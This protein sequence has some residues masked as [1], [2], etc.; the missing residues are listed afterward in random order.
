MTPSAITPG[1]FI[2]L[3]PQ[4]HA[5][6]HDKMGGAAQQDE[7]MEYLVTAEAGVVPARPLDGVEHAAHGVKHSS[8]QQPEEALGGQG[9]VDGDDGEEGQP[10]QKNVDGAGEPPGN[11]QPGDGEDRSG[12]SQGPHGGQQ[13][14]A[15]GV[16]QDGE[17]QGGVAAGDEQ[18]DGAVVVFPQGQ[19]PGDRD[20]QAVVQGA[21][22]VQAD[23]GQTVNGEQSEQ[24]PPAQ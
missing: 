14:H 22:G 2:R 5:V 18:V 7:H 16:P 4:D 6:H 21:G 3:Q 1:R 12:R 15:A 24:Q 9:A 10:A 8:G 13:G 11:L 19:P 20:A 23:H 17:A